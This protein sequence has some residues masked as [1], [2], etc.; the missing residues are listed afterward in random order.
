MRV[1]LY[2]GPSYFSLQIY[3]VRNY[4]FGIQI[5]YPYKFVMNVMYKSR[6]KFHIPNCS[7]IELQGTE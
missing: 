1:L 5:Y 6:W 7:V 4:S 3:S 2:E